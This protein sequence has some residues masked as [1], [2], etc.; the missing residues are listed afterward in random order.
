MFV[1]K[2]LF[3]LGIEIF[4]FFFFVAMTTA[5]RFPWRPKIKRPGFNFIEDTI[6]KI[7]R[8]YI[9]PFERKHFLRKLVTWAIKFY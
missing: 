9:L 5:F 4:K 6:V 2:S 7:K 1:D 8:L 3:L